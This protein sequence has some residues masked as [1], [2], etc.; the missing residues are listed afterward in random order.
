MLFKLLPFIALIG[1]GIK[2]VASFAS[3]YAR[4]QRLKAQHEGRLDQYYAD[5]EAFWRKIDRASVAIIAVVVVW[6]VA[7]V[8]LWLFNP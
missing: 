1:I 5:R 6:Y 2:F 7:G 8:L 3:L 4:K